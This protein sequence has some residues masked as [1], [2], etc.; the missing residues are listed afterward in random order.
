MSDSTSSRILV[1]GLGA[2]TPI[3]LSPDTFWDALMRGKSGAGPI[4]RFDATDFKTQIAGEL[5]GFD[6]QDYM[7]RKQASRFDP[8]AQYGLAA[9]RQAVTD[10]ALDIEALPQS[11]K[12][13]IGVVFGTGQGGVGLFE[14]QARVLFEHGPDR[15]SPF[16]VPMMIPNM[17]AGIIAME[18]GLRGPNHC[19]VSACATGNHAIGDAVAALKSGQADVMICGGAE[20]PVTPLTIGGFA[21]MRAL[22]TRND[23]PTRASRPFDK[24]RDG[25]VASEGAGA[26]VLE[27]YEHAMD[28]GAAI[29]AEFTG[30]GASAD[31]YHYAAPEPNGEGVVLAMQRAMA[32]AAVTPADIDYVNL[33][34]TSTPAGDPIES[35]AIEQAFGAHAHH[36]KLSST[37]SMT[38]HLLGAAG[39]IE[40]IAAILAIRRGAVPPTINLDTP[41]PECTLDYTPNEPVEMD[42][43]VVAN[44]AFGFG[45]HNTTTI[46]R[47]FEE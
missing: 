18:L 46:F 24:D 2:L 15:I 42:I 12:D 37:K 38:G 35:K 45:G 32:E 33:H 6:P 3:G 27:T 34:A 13:R 5:D 44:N 47:R 40:A 28:R 10:A 31:A 43:D 23:D 26:L 41:D 16:L 30:F 7:E 9:A 17:A 21:A 22:S 20:A 8:F 36:V 4:T 39:A 14:E 11:Q 25:F 29:Y 19:V 1:T